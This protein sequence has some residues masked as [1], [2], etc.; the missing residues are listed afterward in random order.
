MFDG[1]DL[2]DG[3]D[4]RAMAAMVAAGRYPPPRELARIMGPKISAEM[5]GLRADARDWRGRLI[6]GDSDPQ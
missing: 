4:F 5:E 2:F 6:M 3:T 1:M